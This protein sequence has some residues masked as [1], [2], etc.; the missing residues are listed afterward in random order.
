MVDMKKVIAYSSLM[1]L[2][3]ASCRK[4]DNPKLPVLESVPLPLVLKVAGTDQVISATDPSSFNA[5]FTVDLYFHEGTPPQK[6][7]VVAIKNGDPTTVKVIQENVTAF[8]TT[9]TLT[10]Q[11]LIDLFGPIKV[12]DNFDVSVDITT[13]SGKKY[14]A[15]PTAGAGYGSNVAIQPGASTSIR[16]TAVCQF[17]ADAYNGNFVVQTDEIGNFNAGDIVP[18]TKVDATHLSFEYPVFDPEPIVI[19]IDPVTNIATVPK[20]V[21][22]NYGTPPAWPYGD[23]SVQSV[24]GNDN[25][26][27]P[28]QGILSLNLEHTVS[29]GSFGAFK[30]VLKKQ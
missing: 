17:N 25:F 23:V 16:Y 1:L 13:Q 7:D 29:A 28:C 14:L 3:F 24:A 8:P 26:V 12:D 21:Y 15:F 27:A 20:Q 18:V 22:G 19:T 30:I 11:K 2:A 4:D 9:I 10:G 6:F 5:K